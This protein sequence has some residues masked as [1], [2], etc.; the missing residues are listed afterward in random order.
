MPDH[1]LAAVQVPHL[2][3]EVQVAD[4]DAPGPS[5]LDRRGAEA[6]LTAAHCPVNPQMQSLHLRDRR[7]A[8]VFAAHIAVELAVLRI[9]A[10]FTSPSWRES[11]I[12]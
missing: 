2:R 6:G 8:V 12:V 9:D 1:P 5:V 11:N 7:T 4:E 10:G 3:V